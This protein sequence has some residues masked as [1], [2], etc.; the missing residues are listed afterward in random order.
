M[1]EDQFDFGKCSNLKMQ[2]KRAFSRSVFC[3][4]D[5]SVGNFHLLN[6]L[7]TPFHKTSRKP[8]LE[9]DLALMQNASNIAL[10]AF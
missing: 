8:S 4:N 9:L 2:F 10:N 1:S 3:R 6:I 7:K 5:K